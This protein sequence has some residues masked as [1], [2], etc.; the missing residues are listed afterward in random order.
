MI[1]DN[2]EEIQSY[3]KNSL[4]WKF[5]NF[6]KDK[7]TKYEDIGYSDHITICLPSV[8]NI[9][10]SSLCRIYQDGSLIFINYD[11]EFIKTQIDKFFYKIFIYTNP[12]M[13]ISYEIY[14]EYYDSIKHKASLI[15]VSDENIMV[16]KL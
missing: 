14:E 9:N 8:D 13:K 15:C 16:K 2:P 6:L 1:D 4:N 12:F 7:L 5:I 10:Y 3:I 11:L